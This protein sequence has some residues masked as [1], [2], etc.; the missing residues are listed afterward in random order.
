MMRDA[1]SISI[2]DS[3]LSLQFKNLDGYIVHLYLPI[4]GVWLAGRCKFVYTWANSNE[5][6]GF[7]YN[8]TQ[9]VEL[10]V[11]MYFGTE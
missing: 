9:A 3:Y 4:G 2:V 11:I 7:V 8:F 10:F 5:Q 1:N 6:R